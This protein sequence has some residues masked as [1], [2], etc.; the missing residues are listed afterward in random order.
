MDKISYED[1]MW[2]QTF[3]EIGFG[4]CTGDT[5][6]S[7]EDMNLNSAKAICLSFFIS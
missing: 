3:R 7:E 6:F 2:T 5:N 1:K 4:H